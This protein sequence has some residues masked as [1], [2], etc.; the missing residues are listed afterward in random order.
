MLFTGASCAEM[1]RLSRLI[2]W[3]ITGGGGKQNGVPWFLAGWV[4][5]FLI[6]IPN[7]E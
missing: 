2:L 1:S 4:A 5:D 7:F 6:L 3:R